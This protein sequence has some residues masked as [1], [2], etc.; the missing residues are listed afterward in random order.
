MK[1]FKNIILQTLLES[2]RIVISESAK[3]DAFFSRYAKIH[4]SHPLIAANP[5]EAKKRILYV[6][7]FAANHDEATYLSKAAL[8]NHYRVG[9]DDLAITNT[10]KRWRKSKKEGKISENMADFTHNKLN[11]RLNEID[12]PDYD[13]NDSSKTEQ[14][15]GSIPELQKFHIGN[16]SDPKHGNLSVYHLGPN[17]SAVEAKKFRTKLKTNSVN[18]CNWCVLDGSEGVSHLKNYRQGHGFFGYAN[19]QGRFVLA[20]GRGDRGIVDPFNTVIS[21]KPRYHIVD[22]T[23]KLLNKSYGPNHEITKDYEVAIGSDLK[24]LTPS[25][26][27]GRI[28]THLS[29][30]N[31]HEEINHDDDDHRMTDQEKFLH[32]SDHFASSPDTHPE[33][34]KKL[35]VAHMNMGHHGKYEFPFEDDNPHE[36][37]EK[38]IHQIINH[39]NAPSDLIHHY[40]GVHPNPEI[41][42]PSINDRDPDD[43]HWGGVNKFIEKSSKITKQMALDAVDKTEDGYSNPGSN[44]HKIGQQMIQHHAI[45]EPEI[46]KIVS[47]RIGDDVDE[48]DEHHF[49]EDSGHTQYPSKFEHAMYSKYFKPHHAKQIIQG[50]LDKKVTPTDMSHLLR[51][52]DEDHVTNEDLHKIYNN[53]EEVPDE[54]DEHRTSYVSA[55]RSSVLDHPNFIPSEKQ[56]EN[57]FLHNDQGSH[58]KHKALKQPWITPDHLDLAIMDS[59]ASIRQRAYSHPRATQQHMEEL[60]KED[61]RDFSHMRSFNMN[62]EP[63]TF[64]RW[65]ES[66]ISDFNLRNKIKDDITT[67][68][69]KKA[70]QRPS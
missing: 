54:N 17:H 14:P 11:E 38:K 2:K 65:R 70:I 30:Y 46:S 49:T 68:V 23:E 52:A 6:K 29:K 45:R 40:L 12:P 58:L 44:M 36:N 39:K 19:N 24:R 20:H 57:M 5:E 21:G 25:E 60:K 1:S 34:L 27:I 8:H 41:T 43:V 3:D 61:S 42:T 10:L 69:R 66:T 64:N 32:I 18:N 37:N 15:G 26:V 53:F 55:I 56:K 50:F 22:N 4:E 48:T 9:E 47:D 35:Y 51:H 63:T 28:H 59:D 33:I 16:F 13:V 7:P 62:Y 31:E 67:V